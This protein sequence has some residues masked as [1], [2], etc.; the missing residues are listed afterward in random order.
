[1]RKLLLPVLLLAG[2]AACQSSPPQRA[3]LPQQPTLT[4]PDGAQSVTIAAGPEAVREA[5]V[6]SAKERGTAVVQDEANMVVMERKMAGDTA[7]LDA[8]FG[9]SD[10]GDRI[11]R[12]RVRFTGEPCRTLA[13]QDLAVVNN[14]RTAL[15]QSFV[16]PGN[17]NTLQSLQGL[18]QRAERRSGCPAV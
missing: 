6:S 10:N 3:S 1:M 9:P 14:A 7:A 5:L 2:L 17:P 18:K 4:I 16:L 11:I 8:E 13:V 15:E 12:I